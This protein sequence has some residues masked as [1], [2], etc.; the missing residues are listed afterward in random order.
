MSPTIGLVSFPDMKEHG[1]APFSRTL[2]NLMDLEA[3][4]L[5]ATAYFKTEEILRK[6]EDKL[7][8][9]CIFQPS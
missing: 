7:K 8:L 2:K 9:V 5:I 4:K 6:H 3:R 1:K